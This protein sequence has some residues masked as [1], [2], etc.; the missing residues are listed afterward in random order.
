MIMLIK[1]PGWSKEYQQFRKLIALY[2]YNVR[3]RSHSYVLKKKLKSYDSWPKHIC[4]VFGNGPSLNSTDL[5]LLYEIPVIVSNGFMFHKN[6]ENFKKRIFT[7]VDKTQAEDWHKEFLK[8]PCDFISMKNSYAHPLNKKTASLNMLGNIDP[9]KPQFS[10]DIFNGVWHASTVTYVNL[11]LAVSLGFK[12]ILLIGV[13]HDYGELEKFTELS[14]VK[15]SAKDLGSGSHFTNNY[16]KTGQRFGVP[17]RV[18]IESAM[19]AA[20]EWAENNSVEI[21]DCTVNGKLKL[22]AKSTIQKELIDVN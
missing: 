15:L 18:L 17:N 6:F 11:Q 12:K 10:N 14:K 20:E 21:V 2:R 16:Y 7:N 3:L 5:S 22:F 1:I 9:I 13:D 19:A 4:V 8:N